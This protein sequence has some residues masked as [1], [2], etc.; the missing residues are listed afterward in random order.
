M[1]KGT[2]ELPDEEIDILGGVWEDLTEFRSFC[3]HGAGT[4]HLPSV[5]LFARLEFSKHSSI[6]ILWRLPHMGTINY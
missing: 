1:I 3:S 5:D 2:D 4:C 6:G